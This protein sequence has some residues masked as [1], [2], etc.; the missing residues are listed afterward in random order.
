MLFLNREKA[1]DFEHLNISTT[2]ITKCFEIFD[3]LYI[4]SMKRDHCIEV[5]YVNNL[6][7]AYLTRFFGSVGSVS[8][9]EKDEISKYVTIVII[10]TIEGIYS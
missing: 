3:K 5:K 1:N 2:L 4:S 8:K 7:V 6:S 10:L 9:V